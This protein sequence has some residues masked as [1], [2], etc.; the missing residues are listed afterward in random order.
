MPGGRRFAISNSDLRQIILMAYGIRDYQLIGAPDWIA[1]ERF[2]VDGRV[3]DD[4]AGRPQ[5]DIRLMLQALL[6]DRFGLVVRR[7]TRELPVYALTMARTDGRLGPQLRRARY[8]CS[9]PEG[10]RQARAEAAAGQP[11]PCFSSMSSGD[12]TVTGADF[13]RLRDML[14]SFLGTNIV[15]RTGLSGDFE[16]SLKWAPDLNS[17]GPTLVTAV[18]EQ[19]ALKLQ[20]ERGHVEVIVVERVERPTAN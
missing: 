19:L 12:W 17:D 20:R 8:A 18:E 1:S 9:T 11:L 15:D 16:W 14:A 4:S 10:L 3:S 5:A 2:D 6:A 7:E 13:A